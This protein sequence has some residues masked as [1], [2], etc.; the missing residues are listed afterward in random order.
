MR[1]TFRKTDLSVSQ[2]NQCDLQITICLKYF[3]QFLSVFSIP[4]LSVLYFQLLLKR[5]FYQRDENSIY[6]VLFPPTLTLQN[7]TLKIVVVT[8]V[9]K[10]GVSFV[11]VCCSFYCPWTCIRRLNQINKT[12]YYILSLLIKQPFSKEPVFH[13]RSSAFYLENTTSCQLQFLLGM[14][15]LI[16]LGRL[17]RKYFKRVFADLAA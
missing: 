12:L 15:Y 3:G 17:L 1:R 6:S 4:H 16:S 2:E 8:A 13:H 5:R 9:I 11:F 10:L 14:K 7:S